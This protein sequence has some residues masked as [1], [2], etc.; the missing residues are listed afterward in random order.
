MCL[1]YR[2]TE[3][4]GMILMGIK[5]TPNAISIC[6]SLGQQ[7]AWYF[8][9]NNPI[10][11]SEFSCI[12]AIIHSL[13]NAPDNYI[14]ININPEPL[15]CGPLTYIQAAPYS[16]NLWRVEFHFEEPC[17]FSYTHRRKTI[18]HNHPWTNLGSKFHSADDVSAVFRQVLCSNSVPAL[19]GWRNY[20][21]SIYL[22]R[23]K[24]RNKPHSRRN[25]HL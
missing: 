24:K 4:Q 2:V 5:V 9:L 3:K 25:R 8:L 19:Y 14:V 7:T 12:D 21:K 11:P 18:V 10:Q 20:T 15:S 23:Y 22:E 6:Y 1:K 16:K 13:K 17:C